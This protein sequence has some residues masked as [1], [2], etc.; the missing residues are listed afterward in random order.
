MGVE[1]SRLGRLWIFFSGEGKEPGGHA[2]LDA[3]VVKLG[4]KKAPTVRWLSY[5]QLANSLRIVV[6]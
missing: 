6:A 3:F 1:K 2:E 4:P 5:S